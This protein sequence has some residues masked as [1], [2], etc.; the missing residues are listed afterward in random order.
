MWW[1][2]GCRAIL[3]AAGS[4]VV[5]F[6]LPFLAPDF[7]GRLPGELGQQ[8]GGRAPTS[9]QLPWTLISLALLL[10]PMAAPLATQRQPRRVTVYTLATLATVALIM[11][12]AT[13]PGAGAYHF[14]PLV[15]VLAD[16]RHRLWPK[17]MDAEFTTFIILFVGWLPVQYTLQTLAAARGSDLVGAEALA[18]ARRSPVQP[19]QTGY[20]DNRQSYELSQLSKTVLSLN[21]YPVLLDAQV[22][23]ELRQIGIDGSARW[24]PYLRCASGS[25]SCARREAVRH[26]QLLLRRSGG[27]QRRVPTSVPR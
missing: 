7:A 10:L 22:L 4:S 14:L 15:P 21:S 19:V 17:G 11:Y 24:I 9:A 18:T 3:I 6:M 8:V 2:G 1:I 5:T 27:V 23:M 25:G 26:S 16:L 20:G 13:F 12:P